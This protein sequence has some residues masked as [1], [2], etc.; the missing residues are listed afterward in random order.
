M[1]DAVYICSTDYTFKLDKNVELGMITPSW[2]DR[3][4]VRPGWT[5]FYIHL[6]PIEDPK[7]IMSYFEDIKPSL[8]LF[9]RE[10]QHITIEIQMS[11]SVQNRQIEISRYHTKTDLVFL[12]DSRTSQEIFLTI[13]HMTKTFTKEPK[14]LGIEESEV[15]LAFPLTEKGEPK[16]EPQNVCAYLPV[17]SFGSSV[18]ILN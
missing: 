10:L 7:V 6:S 14:R 9:L 8:L 18:S 5:S 12:E 16:I 4:P 11:D 1:A 15:V 17:K 13:K 3:Y 2:S